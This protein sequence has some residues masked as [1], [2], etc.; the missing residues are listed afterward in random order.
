M[1]KIYVGFLSS[2]F[3]L[4]GEIKVL[5]DSNFQERIFKKGSKLYINEKKYII[6]SS[7]I[8]KKNYVIAFEGYDDINQI[9]FLL[10]NDIYINKEDYDFKDNE[11]LY[12]ELLDMQIDSDM[13]QFS[14]DDILLG[15]KEV[16]FKCGNLI[17]PYNEKYIVRIDKASK[18][19]YAKNVGDL[20]IWK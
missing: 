10:K 14:I 17:I 2:P 8:I 18:I 7:K 4:K 15:K 3:G 19:I 5:S 9:D 11:F 20:R 16:F 12:I 1:D 13:G 6:N